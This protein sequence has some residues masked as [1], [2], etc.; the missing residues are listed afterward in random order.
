LNF[1][2]K[3]SHPKSTSLL[4]TTSYDVGLLNAKIRPTSSSVYTVARKNW[5]IKKWSKH[6]KVFG[7]YFAYMGGG[8]NLWADWP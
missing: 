5:K 7:V 3:F 6:S 8:K 4:I 1:K 2:I